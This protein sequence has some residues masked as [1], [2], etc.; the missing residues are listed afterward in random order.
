MK[1]KQALLSLIFIL[2]SLVIN[3]QD[4]YEFMIIEYN[5]S[6]KN[7]IVLSIDGKEFISEDAAFVNQKE[8][9][10]NSNP[11]INKVKEYQEKGWELMSFE[12]LPAANLVSKTYLAYLRK[13]KAEKK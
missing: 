2:F 12:T 4:K 6:A 11:L 10:L 9:V 1:V 13:K 5:H 8:S 7:Q 3:A